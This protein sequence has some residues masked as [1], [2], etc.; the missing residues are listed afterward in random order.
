ML[1]VSERNIEQQYWKILKI[2]VH[3][4]VNLQTSARLDSG[5]K[6]LNLMLNRTGLSNG[7]FA[8]PLPPE[9]ADADAHS[10]TRDAA[11]T[12]MTD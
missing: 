9:A 6:L 5:G 8:H 11:S 2:E 7:Q 12:R 1:N 10:H 3:V 4:S